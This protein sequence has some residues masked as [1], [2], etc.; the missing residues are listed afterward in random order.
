MYTARRRRSPRT[1]SRRTSRARSFVLQRSVVIYKY[2]PHAMRSIASIAP[3]DNANPNK[4]PMKIE[5]SQPV[6]EYRV[7]SFV[8]F[9]SARGQN[10]SVHCASAISG[11][12]TPIARSTEPTMKNFQALLILFCDSQQPERFVSRIHERDVVSERI[13]DRIFHI[14]TDI[15]SGIVQKLGTPRAHV[16][17]PPGVGSVYFTA[18]SYA[19]VGARECRRDSAVCDKLRARCPYAFIDR[20]SYGK[21]GGACVRIDTRHKRRIAR[22]TSVEKCR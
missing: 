4:R 8:P 22:Q 13:N 19:Y 17:F 16:H 14:N 15:A 6:S 10:P 5:R 12:M 2:P 20:C 7:A 18:E 9:T 21:H 11:A 1:V 3:I